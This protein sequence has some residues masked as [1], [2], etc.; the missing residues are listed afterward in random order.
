MYFDFIE[1]FFIGSSIT[2]IIISWYNY[3]RNNKLL[4]KLDKIKDLIKP[5]K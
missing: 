4:K 1:G 5:R 3:Y 2:I